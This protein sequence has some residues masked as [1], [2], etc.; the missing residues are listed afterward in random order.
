MKYARSDIQSYVPPGGV[1]PGHSEGADP[2]YHGL[3]IECTACEPHLAK[4]P[5]WSS[6][7]HTV[8]LTPGEQAQVDAQEREAQA[9]TAQF[10]ASLADAAREQVAKQRAAASTTKP[11]RK[12]RT[13][14]KAAAQ[15]PSS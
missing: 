7:P 10:A 4:D 12:P 5:L 8:P 15:K 3:S 1:C 14:R 13:P 2:D 11:A 9:V 6:T